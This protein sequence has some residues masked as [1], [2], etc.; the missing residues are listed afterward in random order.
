VVEEEEARGGDAG[1]GGRADAGLAGGRAAEAA[2][3][4][5]AR[6]CRPRPSSCGAA[7]REHVH[8]PVGETQTRTA[9]PDRIPRGE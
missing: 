3:C 8:D 9:H 1:T 5:R 6:A 7:L 2:S 4:G